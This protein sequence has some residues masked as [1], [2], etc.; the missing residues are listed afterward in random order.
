MPRVNTLRVFTAGFLRYP[1]F[2][3]LNIV[4]VYIAPLISMY[5]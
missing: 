1:Y 5:K 4:Y 2:K 3:L